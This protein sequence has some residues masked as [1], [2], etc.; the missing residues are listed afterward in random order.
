[1]YSYT[2][3][4]IKYPTQPR[5]YLSNQ[6]IFILRAIKYPT[7]PA[8]RVFNRFELTTFEWWISKS[9]RDLIFFLISRINK[10]CSPLVFNLQINKLIGIKD[11]TF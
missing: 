10:G 2:R 1:M 4:A 7:K 6:C 11:I 5:V 9:M 3:R 8:R